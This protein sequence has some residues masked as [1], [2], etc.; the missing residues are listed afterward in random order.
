MMMMTMMIDD[1]RLSPLDCWKS[2]VLKK[3]LA[4]NYSLIYQLLRLF[5]TFSIPIIDYHIAH[6]SIQNVFVI[7]FVLPCY[8][9]RRV[10]IK[11]EKIMQP[12]K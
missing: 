6:I 10:Q 11:L 8:H 12:N 9:S 7:V 1:G 5:K 3:R 2:R 4:R